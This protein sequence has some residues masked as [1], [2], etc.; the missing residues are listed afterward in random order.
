MNVSFFIARRYLVSKKSHHAINIISAIS[1]VGVAVATLALVCTLSVFNGFR[2]LVA[3]LFTSFDPQL[4][5]TT[6]AGVSVQPTTRR[7][8]ASVAILTCR[9]SQSA[10]RTRRSPCSVAV[11]P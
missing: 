9:S 10:W 2:D 4:E 3:Q 7:L 6:A 1:V 8:P 5:V 11:K